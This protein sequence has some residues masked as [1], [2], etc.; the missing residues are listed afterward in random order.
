MSLVTYLKEHYDR[1]KALLPSIRY[2]VSLHSAKLYSQMD[3]LE[4]ISTDKLF[5]C[6]YLYY[7]HITIISSS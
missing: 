7:N 2:Y 6:I 5:V 1:Y 3:S 4:E